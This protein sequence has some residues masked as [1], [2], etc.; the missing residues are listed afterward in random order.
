MTNNKCTQEG[1]SNTANATKDTCWSCY[2]RIRM[3]GDNKPRPRGPARIYE[4][5]CSVEDCWR[6]SR[7][8]GLCHGHY[9][10]L[11]IH[12]HP[13]QGRPIAKRT[14]PGD[15]DR[16]VEELLQTDP[17]PE[18]CI[19]WPFSV[20]E[21][22]RPY[23]GNNLASRAILSIVIGDPGTHDDNKVLHS[24]R[25]KRLACVNP[26]HMSWKPL[27][28]NVRRRDTRQSSVPHLYL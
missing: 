8:K 6:T 10:R 16:W 14:K 11:L 25:G 20:R 4:P 22:G 18:E 27:P 24:C 5:E 15:I 26:A 13:T 7:A 28:A 21:K 19:R 9:Q 12:G 2:N 23:W 1:C 17:L 3:F